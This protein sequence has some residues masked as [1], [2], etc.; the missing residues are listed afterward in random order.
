MKL[1]AGFEFIAISEVL[2]LQ[3]VDDPEWLPV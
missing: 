1:E 3:N 2:I